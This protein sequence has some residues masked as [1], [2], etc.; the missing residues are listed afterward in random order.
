MDERYSY[1]SD[2]CRKNVAEHHIFLLT[3]LLIGLAILW[4]IGT[5]LG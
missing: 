3:W 2:E 1:R 4:L 5:F